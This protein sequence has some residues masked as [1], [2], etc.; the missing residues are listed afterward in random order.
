MTH[1]EFNRGTSPVILAFP[2]TGIQL[3]GG[4]GDRLNDEGCKL[5]DTDWHINLLYGG[6]LPKATTVRATFHRYVIDANRDPSGASLYPGQNTTSLVPLTDFDDQPIWKEGLEPTDT[7]VAER[8]AAYHR[9]YHAVLETEI[10]RVK[11][12][13]GIA[14]VYDCHSIRSRC[15]FLFDGVLPDFNIGTDNGVTC[16]PEIERAVA[17]ICAG[18]E[19]YTS[20]LN[21]RFRGGWTTRHYGRPQTGVHAIQM[22]LA[23]IT[24][25]ETETPPFELDIGK[26][27][28][29]TAVLKK[30]LAAIERTALELAGA[31][32]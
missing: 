12:L 25:L 31:S 26:E 21:G 19:G 10:A 17:D 23:R 29:L 27:R 1:V 18:A 32:R 3:P 11:A 2:H 14:V 9:P 24:H 7:D 15:P 30:V 4:V 8:V 5:R 13:H 20:V 22:E 6:L 28:R 16:A